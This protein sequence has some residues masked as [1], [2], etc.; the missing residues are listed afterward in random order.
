MNQ[1]RVHGVSRFRAF[2]YFMLFGLMARNYSNIQYETFDQAKEA[3]IR[4]AQ[5]QG[6]PDD[7]YAIY[8][9]WDKRG[10]R[11]WRISSHE[12]FV[13]RWD[14]NKCN[15]PTSVRTRIFSATRHVLQVR[16][17]TPSNHETGSSSVSQSEARRPRPP[18]Q[19]MGRAS[20]NA[21]HAGAH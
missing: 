3:A 7:T 19:V 6:K 14:R 11:T 20:T 18:V 9:L 10:V 21:F 15:R 16:R 2:L 13:I 12:T 8:P 1:A 17:E 5:K 4:R